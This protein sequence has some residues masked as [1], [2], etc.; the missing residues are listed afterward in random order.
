M[1][2]SGSMGAA[3]AGSD[4]TLNGGQSLTRRVLGEVDLSDFEVIGADGYVI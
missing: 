3:V 1:S 2:A 4:V